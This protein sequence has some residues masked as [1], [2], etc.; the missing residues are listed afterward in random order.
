[1][2]PR[3]LAVVP[4]ALAGFLI[5]PAL[6]AVASATAQTVT[7]STACATSRPHSGKILHG[8]TNGGLG[9][10]TITDNLS[11]DVVVILVRGRSKVVSVYVR[12]HA[13]T[14]LRNITDGSYTIY[15]TIGSQY[16]VCQGQFTRE[17][18][19]WRIDKRLTFTGQPPEYIAAT[20][21]LYAANG[22]ATATPIGPTGFPTP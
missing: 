17:A 15:Y 9:T 1:M 5:T 2:R 12:A 18:S 11:H 21:I 6:P 16:S 14:S 22:N 8:G 3:W 7:T 10:L 4:L 19:Y 13:R 20:F